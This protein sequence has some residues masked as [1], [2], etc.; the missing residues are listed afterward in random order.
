MMQT[1]G[2]Y[3]IPYHDGLHT[4]LLAVWEKSVLATHF[5]LKPGD[6]AAIQ[7]LV[8]EIDFNHFQVYCLLEQTTLAGFIGV[9]HRK[10]EML[11]L[12]PDYFRMGLG[13]KLMDF[14]INVLDVNKV[15]VNEQNA[16]AVQF[17]QSLG[18]T[19]YERTDRDDQGYEYPL[20]RMRL[21]D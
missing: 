5:F 3:I 1:D 8:Q 10:V 16:A 2:Q 9:L 20:L 21:T 18:F 12:A 7:E 17:Y 4:Q 13:R 11:F 19:V 14:A 6:L 15:D